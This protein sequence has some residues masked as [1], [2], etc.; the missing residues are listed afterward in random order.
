MAFCSRCENQKVR[1][2]ILRQKRFFVTGESL[3]C[4]PQ[5]EDSG[6]I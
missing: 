6:R 2:A 3:D 5:V 4:S 1:P